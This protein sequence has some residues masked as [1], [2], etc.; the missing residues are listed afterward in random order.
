MSTWA[1]T[2]HALQETWVRFV[3]PTY[4][5]YCH[6]WVNDVMINAWKFYVYY[7]EDYYEDY[8]EPI[9]G[10]LWRK[11]NLIAYFVVN[12]YDDVDMYFLW[13]HFA[14]RKINQFVEWV[15]GYEIITSLFGAYSHS[16]VLGSMI[17]GFFGI[18][19]WLRRI[20]IGIISFLLL[21]LFSPL[22]LLVYMRKL[23]FVKKST[24]K[25]KK[26]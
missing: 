18:C 26:H 3:G 4:Y 22:L 17:L 9:V 12:Y 14:I 11:I 25:S 23:L 10:F 7:L 24:K 21:I 13:I 6:P 20:I 16:I 1:T 15:L 8:L 5:R 19:I 2:L